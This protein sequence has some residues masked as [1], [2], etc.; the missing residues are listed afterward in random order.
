MLPTNVMIPSPHGFARAEDYI[1]YEHY[2]TFWIENCAVRYAQA[3]RPH[4]RFGSKADIPA[5][6][7]DVRFTPKSGHWF[8]LSGC[9]LCAKSGREQLQQ[10]AFYS[11]TSSARASNEWGTSRPSALAV[12][13]LITSSYLVGACTGRSAGF[14]PLRIR[15]T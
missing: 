14:A 11:I 12:L 7:P 15:S 5:T 1:G 2:I 4:V 6:S 9:P 13:R 8:R 10:M 3:G